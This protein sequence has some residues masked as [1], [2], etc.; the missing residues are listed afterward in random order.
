M[1][2]TVEG[3]GKARAIE[4][5]TDA[6]GANRQEALCPVPVRRAA[7]IDI[8]GKDKFVVSQIGRGQAL[9]AI[10]IGNLIRRSHAAIA[11]GCAQEAGATDREREILCGKTG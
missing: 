8:G 11:T 10:N 9:Q 5:L 2:L 4:R 6:I 7:G 3:S 1:T